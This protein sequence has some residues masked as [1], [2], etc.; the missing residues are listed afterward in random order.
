MNLNHTRVSKISTFLVALPSSGT[1]RSHCVCWQEECI[2]ITTCCNNYCVSSKSFNLTSNQVTSDDTTST[3]VNQNNVQHFVTSIQFHFTNTNLTAQ[4]WISTQKQLLSGLAA[5]IECTGYLSTTEWT[6]IQQ[7]TIFTSER[8]TLSYALVDNAIGNFSQ[9]I[10]VSFTSTVVTTLDCIIE[11]TING[12]AIILIVLSSIDTALCCDRV[13]TTRRVLDTEVQHI[14]S[15]F[16]QRS[17]SRSTGQTST[18][19]DDIQT[20]LVCRVH[21]F[22]VIFIIFPLLSQWALRDFWINFSHNDLFSNVF[23]TPIYRN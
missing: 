7:S 12:V 20:T 6:V 17:C 15:H 4:C 21:Q 23:F 5:G 14:E 13:C 16:C 3:P 11:Q 10:N 9:T 1:V 18:Y 22:L 19:H 8:N 2:Y